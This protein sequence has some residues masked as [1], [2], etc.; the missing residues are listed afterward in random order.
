M[1]IV[2]YRPHGKLNHETKYY[3]PYPDY[4]DAE[5]AL[6]LLPPIGYQITEE[7]QEY[8]GCKYIVELVPQ[9]PGHDRT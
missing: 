1:H 7:E 5:D 8:P 9:V 2:I 4:L 6:G 3:G